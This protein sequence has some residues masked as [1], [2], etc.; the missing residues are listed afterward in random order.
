MRSARRNYTS[1]SPD[2]MTIIQS[3]AKEPSAKEEDK[4]QDL[5]PAEIFYRL[6]KISYHLNRPEEAVARFQQ[7]LNLDPKH[8]DSLKDLADQYYSLRQWKN[9]APVLEQILT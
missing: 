3:N 6:G 4:V 9:A 7:A 8:I 2:F 5:D 1:R